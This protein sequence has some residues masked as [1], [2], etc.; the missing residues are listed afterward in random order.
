MLVNEGDSDLLHAFMAICL[1]HK[2]INEEL[3]YKYDGQGV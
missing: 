2:D 1:T 3:T